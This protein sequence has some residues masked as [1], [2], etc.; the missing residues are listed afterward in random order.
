M[1]AANAFRAKSVSFKGTA[2]LGITDV[3]TNET[4]SAT[5]L[6][7]DA[8]A[9]VTAIFVD[10]IKADVT[11][12]TTDFTRAKGITIGDT[13]AL[14][15]TYEIRAE[16]KGAG[17]GNAVATYANAV[18]ISNNPQGAT[19]GNGTASIAFSCSAPGGSSPVA[20]S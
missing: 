12:T 1:A 13:G 14:V 2:I 7:T 16:G 5:E 6:K 4:G 15:V 19:D 20:W 10:G 17:A 8:S 18:V 9:T 11:V 3:S